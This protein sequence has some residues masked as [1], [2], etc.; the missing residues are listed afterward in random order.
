MKTPDIKS[1]LV[2]VDFSEMTG[3]ILEYAEFLA[4]K[5]EADLAVLHV[6]H[7]P[8]LAEAG[9][10]MDPIISPSVEKDIREQMTKGAGLQLD[11]ILSGIDNNDRKIFKVV[12][13][14][15]P[16]EQ[17]VKYAGENDID[18]IVMGTHGRTGLSHLIIGSVAERVVRRAPCS[19]F[20]IN[21]GEADK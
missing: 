7:V 8:S 21:P 17:I 3:K 10:W 15:L 12:K 4:H 20:C 11:K 5:F 13:E 1:I 6:V 9:S 2:P 19:V 14:G 18:L 16:F